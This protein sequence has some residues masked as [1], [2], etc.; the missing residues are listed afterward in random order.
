M[1]DERRQLQATAR[2]FAREEVL[3]VANELDPKEADIPDTLLVRLGE[4][5]YFGITIPAE[6]GGMGSTL[7]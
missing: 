2:R 4:M 6:Y 3:P 5:G 7:R 1:T